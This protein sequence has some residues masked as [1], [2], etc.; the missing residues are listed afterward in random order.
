[1]RQP[2]LIGTGPSFYHCITETLPSLPAFTED[3]KNLFV[4]NLRRMEAFT[5]VRVV[6]YSIL[7]HRIRML[8]HVGDLADVSESELGRR[9]KTY[10]GAEAGGERLKI[11][12]QIKRKD[13][14]KAYAK[15]VAK[16]TDRMGSMALFLKTLLQMLTQGYNNRNGTK[17]T[18]FQERFRSILIE[19]WGPALLSTAAF[20]DLDSVRVG[21]VERARDYAY[22]GFG[23]ASRGNKQARA[24]LAILF[25]YLE[26]KPKDWR[27]F[28]SLYRGLLLPPKDNVFLDARDVQ[29]E[30]RKR[31]PWLP[32]SVLLRCELRYFDYG[33]ILGRPEFIE[34]VFHDNRHIFASDRARMSYTMRFANWEGMHSMRNPVKRLVNVPKSFQG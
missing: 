10:Y 21:E 24:G 20:I 11:L 26:D 19:G 1:M 15:A 16:Y 3:D 14:A 5:G 30:L 13:G 29:A 22:S 12:R 18:I 23:S 28:S 27:G 31:R 32:R 25:P 9:L 17:G 8:V 6:T 2:R 34:E 7:D 4:G 33:T